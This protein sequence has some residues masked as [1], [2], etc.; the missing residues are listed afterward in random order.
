MTILAPFGPTD[1]ALL[2]AMVARAVQ[3]PSE[4]QV[5]AAPALLVAYLATPRTLEELYPWGARR[6][7]R[8]RMVRGLVRQ[9]LD[10]GQIVTDGNPSGPADWSW[11][12]AATAAPPAPGARPDQ[13]RLDRLTPKIPELDWHQHHVEPDAAPEAP[14]AEETDETDKKRGWLPETYNEGVCL[15]EVAKEFGVTK[16]RIRQIELKALAKI[17]E[18]A[19]ELF[20]LLTGG[21]VKAGRGRV[22]RPQ[23]PTP[24]VARPAPPPPAPAP[25]PQP[26]K[27]SMRTIH[28][29]GIRERL[30]AYLSEP[31][32]LDEI[33]AHLDYDGTGCH[34]AARAVLKRAGAIRLADG[35]WALTGEPVPLRSRKEVGDQNRAAVLASL[36]DVPQSSAQVARALKMAKSAAYRHLSMLLAEGAAERDPVHGYTLAAPA[37]PAPAP[38]RLAPP[39]V[40]PA[41][42]AVAALDAIEGRRPAKPA[43]GRLAAARAAV[44]ALSPE[45]LDALLASLVPVVEARKALA[46]ALAGLRGA[47]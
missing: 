37:A 28:R 10:A 31:R 15:E 14:A 9:L 24:P 13:E 20:N 41:R 11:L 8:P 44:A 7:Y 6:H 27:A 4:A 36:T 17:R 5:E 19:P 46:A 35:R 34:S 16:E 2:H 43:G 21:T 23:R 22:C 30:V 47:A 42:A 33:D 32:T 3:G 26:E 39:L 45:E 29:P 12:W 38:L 1:S 25:N 40:T 18:R